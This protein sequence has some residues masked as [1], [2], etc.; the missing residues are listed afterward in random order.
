MGYAKDLGAAV[1]GTE[2]GRLSNITETHSD[3]GF[4]RLIKSFERLVPAAEKSGVCIGIEP[5][6]GHTVCTVEKMKSVIDYFKSDSMCVILDPINLINAENHSNHL[7][8]TD[9][10]FELFADKIRAIHLKDYVF[11][12]KANKVPVGSGEFKTAEFLK[13]VEQLNNIPD[14][15][16]DEMPLSNLA[17]VSERLN[18]II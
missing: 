10:A 8:I 18:K 4:S 16:L 11:G 3:K 2:T 12:E 14:I 15:I 13:Q 17:G 5:V 7:Q 6:W 1:I 9:R